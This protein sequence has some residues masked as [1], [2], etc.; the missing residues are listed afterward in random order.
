MFRCNLHYYINNFCKTMH[1]LRK[2]LFVC[3]SRHLKSNKHGW[4]DGHHE[5]EWLFL[6]LG[7]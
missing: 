2:H 3:I 7:S 5:L 4:T 1:I 6:L